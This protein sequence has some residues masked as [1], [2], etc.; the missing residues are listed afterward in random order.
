MDFRIKPIKFFNRPVAIIC[1]NENGPC[2]LIA[3]A[4]ILTLRGKIQISTDRSFISLD[5][6]IQIVADAVFES[7]SQQDGI[8]ELRQQ[9]MEDVLNVLPK[10]ARGLDLNIGFKSVNKYEFTEEISIFD[11]LDISLLH[12]WLVNPDDQRAVEVIGDLS[13]NHL[14]YKIVEY[15]SMLEN[16]EPSSE[17]Q[18]LLEE[19]P[20]ID[21]FLAQSASQLTFTGLLK[22]YEAM[23]DRQLAVFFRNNHFSTLFSFN[24]QLFLL[25][26]DLGYL[27]Q[28]AVIWEL[29]EG[30]D[31]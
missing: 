1:Q 4:N 20:V 9:H 12:G 17:S 15:K 22:L 14:M 26:T 16:S 31:G 21:G 5:E 27:H 28:P 30:V 29:L 24:G 23:N 2:P 25:V 8:E 3:I 18:Q 10:L 13:Y 19:G 6:V 11:A 7:S